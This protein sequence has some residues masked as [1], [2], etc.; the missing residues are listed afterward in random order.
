MNKAANLICV[1]GRPLSPTTPPG[2]EAC[3]PR[4]RA[5]SPPVT[6]RVTVPLTPTPTAAAQRVAERHPA[7]VRSIVTTRASNERFDSAISHWRA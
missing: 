5:R 4:R 6:V 1:G 3:R 7:L 2:C